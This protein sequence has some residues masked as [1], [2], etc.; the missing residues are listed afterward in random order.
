MRQVTAGAPPGEPPRATDAPGPPGTVAGTE[1]PGAPR[2]DRAADGDGDAA[3]R[4]AP[5]DFYARL[6]SGVTVITAQGQDGPAGS[7][8]SAVTSLSADPPLLL[9]CLGTASRTLTVIEERGRFAVNLLAESQRARAE[10]FADPRAGSAERFAGT[11]HRRVLAVPVLTDALGWS[12]CVAEDI[13]RYGDHCLVV[14]RIAAAHTAAGRPLLW[15][16]RSFHH[17]AGRGAARTAPA[18]ARPPLEAP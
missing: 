6:A 9:V 1:E 12:V 17:L 2:A 14:G 16:D 4:A 5:R 13:R 15:H 10:L 8:A 7:T 18:G 3:G 11:D